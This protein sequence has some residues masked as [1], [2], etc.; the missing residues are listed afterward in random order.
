MFV[1]VRVCSGKPTTIVASRKGFYPAGK[2]GLITHS[3][4]ALL[5]QT[6]RPFD[7]VSSKQFVFFFSLFLV[8][9]LLL[10]KSCLLSGCRHTMLL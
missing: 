2:R 1:Q 5:Q 4:V 7:A 8:F 10:L 6:S 9:L 3:L